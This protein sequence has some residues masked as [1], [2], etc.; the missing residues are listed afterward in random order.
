MNADGIV[1]SQD[2]ALISSQW[3]ATPPVI[4]TTQASTA[5]GQSQVATTLVTGHSTRHPG[6]DAIS[7][8]VV[9]AAV[10]E[11][12]PALSTSPTSAFATSV[13]SNVTPAAVVA[14]VTGP[15]EPLLSISTPGAI[16]LPAVATTGPLPFERLASFISSATHSGA[17]AT[18]PSGSVT[19]NQASLDGLD[20]I[21]VR[22][23]AWA[24]SHASD[25]GQPSF[26]LSSLTD[27]HSWSLDDDVLDALLAARRGLR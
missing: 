15:V 11:T 5:T 19:E 26:D 2:L 25:F 21:K 13:T 23:A 7:T 22:A 17:S 24:A 10:S 16:Q 20:A 27:G 18:N 1:N 14:N 8:T 3:L 9:P 6:A 4:L 12:L